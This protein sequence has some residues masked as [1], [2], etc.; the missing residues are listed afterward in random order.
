MSYPEKLRYTKE[1]E[2]IGVED[3]IGTIGIT[4]HAQ[5]EIGDVVFVELPEQGAKLEQGKFLVSVESV[6]SVFEIFAPVSGEVVEANAM[7][8]D[9]PE[10]MNEDPYGDGWIAKVKLTSPDELK[11]LM[12]AAEYQ[13]FVEQEGA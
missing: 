11:A 5:K 6:K 2:W 1:H 3:G 12:T 7:L 13:T 10:K 9:A 8:T 4:F